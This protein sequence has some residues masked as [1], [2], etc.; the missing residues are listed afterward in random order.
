MP[1]KKWTIS[2]K[3]LD[4]EVHNS[5]SFSGKVSEKLFVNMSLL[6]LM[7]SNTRQKIALRIGPLVN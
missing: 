7:R 4:I 3:G 5:W 1:N 6:I 2:Y